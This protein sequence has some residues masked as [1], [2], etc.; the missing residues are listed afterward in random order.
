MPQPSDRKGGRPGGPRQQSGGPP[1]KAGQQQQGQQ[2]WEAGWL[3][4]RGDPAEGR[5]DIGPP[6]N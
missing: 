1:R 6:A 5:P 3:G 4:P 2:G